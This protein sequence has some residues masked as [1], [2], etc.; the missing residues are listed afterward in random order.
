[1]EYSLYLIFGEE[2]II[3]IK[4][5]MVKWLLNKKE[6]EGLKSIITEDIEKNDYTCIGKKSHKDKWLK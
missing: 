6:V 4:P 2:I 5:T 3:N 1:M